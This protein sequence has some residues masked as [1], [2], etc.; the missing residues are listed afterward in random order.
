ML[1]LVEI[2]Q[3]ACELRA[4]KRPPDS[5]ISSQLSAIGRETEVGI[6]PQKGRYLRRARL[7]DAHLRCFKSRIS[8]F[9]TL[10]HL[11]IVRLTPCDSVPFKDPVRVGIHH[12]HEM[13]PRIEQD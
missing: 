6:R 9:E 7:I 11:F 2:T 13:I 12:K 10:P 1:P 4:G 3:A 5:V 8:G